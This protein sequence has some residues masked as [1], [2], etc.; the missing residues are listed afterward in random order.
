MV[1]IRLARRGSKKRPFYHINVC[2]SRFARDGRYIE[3]IGF[4]N[5]IAQKLDTQSLQLDEERM[6]HWVSKGAQPSPRVKS[7]YKAL[8][9]M[10]AVVAEPEV[11]EE[12]ATKQALDSQ[13]ETLEPQEVTETQEES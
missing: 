4:F 2:D 10:P 9:K 7:L 3:K 13:E 12:E 11:V 6:Q 5:P 1:V 8:K